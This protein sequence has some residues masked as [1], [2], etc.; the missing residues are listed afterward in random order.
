MTVKSIS[1]ES[2]K[3]TTGTGKRKTFSQWN[4]HNKLKFSAVK[5]C[6]NEK[7]QTGIKN[8]CWSQNLP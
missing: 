5:H 3:E 7:R 6:G 2:P 1:N 4:S 8:G